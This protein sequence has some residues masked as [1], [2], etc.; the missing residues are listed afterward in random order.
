[1][2][3]TRKTTAKSTKTSTTKSTKTS[4]MTAAT[5]SAAAKAAPASAPVVVAAAVPVVSGP[6]M[7]KPEL[8]D[9]VVAKTGMKKKDV[10]PIIEAALAVLGSALQSGRELNLEPMGKIKINREKKLPEGKVMHAK[11]RQPKDLPSETA[12]PDPK[13]IEGADTTPAAAE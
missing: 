12:N 9:A 11:I 6:K 2:A 4:S 8:V 5:K 3:T 13:D 7:R 10:K 1:M